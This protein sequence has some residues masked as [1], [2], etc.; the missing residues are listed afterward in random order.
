MLWICILLD[1]KKRKAQNDLHIGS[2]RPCMPFMYII[3]THK[4]TCGQWTLNKVTIVPSL[5]K[6]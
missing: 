2:H 5:G 1:V 4:P 3:Y 6:R